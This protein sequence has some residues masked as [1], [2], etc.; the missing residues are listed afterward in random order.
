MANIRFI[1][2]SVFDG[3]TVTSYPGDDTGYNKEYVIDDRVAIKWRSINA[4]MPPEAAP[5]IYLKFDAGVGNQV[6][7][8]GCGL[9]G[10]RVFGATGDLG[11]S[12]TIKLS[13]SDDGIGWTDAGTFTWNKRNLVLYLEG[14]ILARYWRIGFQYASGEYQVEVGRAYGGAFTELSENCWAGTIAAKVARSLKRRSGGGQQYYKK[15]NQLFRVQGIRFRDLQDTDRDTLLDIFED[16]DI[17]KPMIISLD[18]DNHLNLLTWYG[19]FDSN[20]PIQLLY[21]GVSDVSFNFEQL[22]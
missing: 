9:F 2:E 22:L 14:T 15:R 4:V 20:F 13:Y 3:C 1:S 7:V 17:V 19:C 11:S 8:S 5:R 6:G 16:R 12:T 21:L 18:P 10:V